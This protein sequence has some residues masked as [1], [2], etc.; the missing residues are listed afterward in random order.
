MAEVRVVGRPRS[1]RAI[2]P[3]WVVGVALVSVCPS[4]T[5]FENEP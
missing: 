2:S 5:E 3:K 4:A 1:V